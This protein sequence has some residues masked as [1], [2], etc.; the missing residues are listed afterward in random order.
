METDTKKEKWLCPGTAWLQCRHRFYGS[1]SGRC[2]NRRYVWTDENTVTCSSTQN[3]QKCHV[4]WETQR[5]VTM[6][7]CR[8]KYLLLQNNTLWLKIL[9]TTYC[10][11]MN[12]SNVCT[13]QTDGIAHEGAEIFQ[14]CETLHNIYDLLWWMHSDCWEMLTHLAI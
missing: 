3:Q 7:C 2:H 13:A 12:C 6:W 8:N 11:S 14:F 1:S 10:L 5:N 9:V 4:R